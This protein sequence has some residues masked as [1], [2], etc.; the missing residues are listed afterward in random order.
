MDPQNEDVIGMVTDRLILRRWRDADRAPFAAMNADPEVMRYFMK[1]LD[2]A[3]SDAFIDRIERHF[4]EHG[5]GLWAL[6]RLD[7]GMFIGYAGP[8]PV[9]FDAHFA[10]AVEV[11]WRLDRSAWGHGFATEAAK[12]AVADAYRRA[13]IPEILSF[14]ATSNER[15]W[16][17]MERLGMHRVAGGDFE[18][19]WVTVGHEL[20]SHV[21]Y[22]FPST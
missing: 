13:G 22:R 16:R 21:L 14:T 10:P 11:G 12:A 17:V 5:W 3:E 19:P 15:S 18:H 1:S 4:E 9:T 8:W 20:Q 2:R 7:T 6:E